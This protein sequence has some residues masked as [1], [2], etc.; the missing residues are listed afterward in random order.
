MWKTAVRLWYCLSTSPWMAT[1]F[2]KGPEGFSLQAFWT[3]ESLLLNLF[4]SASITEHTVEHTGRY[5][6][7]TF[8]PVASLQEH[9]KL[10]AAL[11]ILLKK[12]M[13]KLGG[14]PTSN[15][16]TGKAEVRG[17]QGYTVKTV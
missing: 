4:Q 5:Q 9:R 7:S 16:S 12:R 11:K 1:F 15:P 14:D 10:L 8:N 2:S 6:A 3:T 17:T 13:K